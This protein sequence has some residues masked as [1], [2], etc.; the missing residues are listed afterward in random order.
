MKKGDTVAPVNGSRN[1]G[2]PLM[3]K[4]QPVASPFDI[5]LY[6]VSGISM[7]DKRVWR[8][9]ECAIKRRS[10]DP[11]ENY[12]A[13]LDEHA[14]NIAVSAN[15]NFVNV[16]HSY[17]RLGLCYPKIKWIFITNTEGQSWMRI[18]FSFIV[19][20]SSIYR[21]P[22]KKYNLI[23]LWLLLHDTYNFCLLQ[24]VL[25]SISTGEIS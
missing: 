8:A 13:L 14:A 5:G 6:T 17:N 7:T 23:D 16:R 3:P 9:S 21:I 15:I 1:L 12:S 4:Y 25:K 20:K 2:W 22:M 11:R 19:C 18:S 24:W 10:N